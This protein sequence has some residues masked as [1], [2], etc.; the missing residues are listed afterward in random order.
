VVAAATIAWLLLDGDETEVEDDDDDDEA[1]AAAEAQ[2]DVELHAATE[3][4]TAAEAEYVKAATEANEQAAAEEEAAT[5]AKRTRAAEAA[6]QAAHWAPEMDKGPRLP[7]GRRSKRGRS[8][9]CR[10]WRRD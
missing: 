1:K 6:E 7:E 10:L 5:E 8:A 2:R 3:R 9:G 4:A